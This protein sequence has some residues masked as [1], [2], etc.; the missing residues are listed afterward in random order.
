MGNNQAGNIAA[1]RKAAA[2]IIDKAADMNA[3]DLCFHTGMLFSQ[4]I[5]NRFRRSDH[6]DRMMDAPF[7]TP[8]VQRIF[9][10]RNNIRQL[11][12]FAEPVSQVDLSRVKRMQNRRLEPQQPV[13]QYITVLTP[14]NRQPQRGMLDLFDRGAKNRPGIHSGRAN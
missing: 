8:L 12:L 13:K 3:L 6:L 10:I 4:L 5:R 2:S 9:V 7:K 1:S 11:K 14:E